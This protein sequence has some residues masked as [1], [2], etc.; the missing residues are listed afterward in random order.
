MFFGN[1]FNFVTAMNVEIKRATP[2]DSATLAGL[3]AEIFYH[4]FAAQNTPEDM[5]LYL[6]ETFTEAKLQ[7]EFEEPGVVYY[8]AYADEQPTGIAKLSRK[9]T[10]EVLQQIPCIELERLYVHPNFQGQK[11]GHKLME[12]CIDTARE[13]GSKVLWLGVW[14]NNSG[15]VRF[16]ERWGFKKFGEHIFQL[17][18][19]AQTDWLMRLEL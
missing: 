9:R 13:Q 16:Y 14:E 2:T 19:D 12:L 8:M 7:Q 17:G 4:T 5:A 15:A 10:P 1:A 3:G 11:I 18:T 6:E